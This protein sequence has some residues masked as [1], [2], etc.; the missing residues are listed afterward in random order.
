MCV[1]RILWRHGNAITEQPLD[2]PL[3][4]DGWWEV[5]RDGPAPRRWTSGDAVLPAPV[6]AGPALLEVQYGAGI[7]GEPAEPRRR[8]AA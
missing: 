7:Y 8:L 2:D 3:L 5:E 1:G 6:R 4:A